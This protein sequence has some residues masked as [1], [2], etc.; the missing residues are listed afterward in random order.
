MFT[1]PYF[2][3]DIEDDAPVWPLLLLTVGSSY[4]VLGP[5]GAV[6]VSGF[7]SMA[8]AGT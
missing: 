7:W 6:G 2:L 1:C 3:V 4:V 8:N 5:V